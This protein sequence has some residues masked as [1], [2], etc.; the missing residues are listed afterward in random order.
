MLAEEPWPP[1]LTMTIDDSSHS[2]SGCGIRENEGAD[3]RE[4]E[5]SPHTKV[6]ACETLIWGHVSSIFLSIP[7]REPPFCPK[8]DLLW[9]KST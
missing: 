3:V 1:L 2:N 5:L 8:C 4:Q 9:M 7:A 6:L